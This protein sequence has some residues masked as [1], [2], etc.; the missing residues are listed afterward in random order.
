M[1]GHFV[2]GGLGTMDPLS[3]TSAVVESGPMTSG[4]SRGLV[5]RSAVHSRSC[6]I[7]NGITA[8]SAPVSTRSGDSYSCPDWAVPFVE[9][10]TTNTTARRPSSDAPPSMRTAGGRNASN[11][12]PGL[13]SSD[14]PAAT[15]TCGGDDVQAGGVLHTLCRR[16]AVQE[17]ATPIAHSRK[18]RDPRLHPSGSVPS[19]ASRRGRTLRTR[20]K[21]PPAERAPSRG[22][23]SGPVTAH[24]LQSRTTAC[25]NGLGV[26]CH[27]SVT[28]TWPPS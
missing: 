26:C 3:N 25:K 21:P 5:P 11:G 18:A 27:L 1:P 12:S 17:G 6:R 24:G 13:S 23:R 20:S 19:N 28:F 22:S 4:T 10:L 2:I 14:S 8:Y 7:W 16:E 15:A 9:V